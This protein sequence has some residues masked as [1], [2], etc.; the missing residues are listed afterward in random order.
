MYLCATWVSILHL[1]TILIYDF[2]IVP[3]VRER[4]FN[5]KG[6]GGGYGFFLKKY[7][8][9][10]CCWKKYSD[11]GGGK[12]NNLI[13]SF[14]HRNNSKIIYQ[15]RRKMQNRYPCSTQIHDRSLSW[16]GTGTSMY[17]LR[18]SLVLPQQGKHTPL[19]K[20]GPS[21]LRN[22][23]NAQLCAT[24]VSI[25]HLSTILIYDFGLYRRDWRHQKGNQKL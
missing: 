14:C 20:G 10:Q 22:K 8:D 7:S 23:S 25:L 12:K 13:Q 1:S 18:N 9:S 4:P 15:N 24:W 6:G 17:I 16:L 19:Q 5:L 21:V 2:G 11:F 3:T